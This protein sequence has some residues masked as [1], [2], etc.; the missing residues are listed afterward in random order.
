MKV[1][2]TQLFLSLDLNFLSHR[3]NLILGRL[4][5]ALAARIIFLAILDLQLIEFDTLLLKPLIELVLNL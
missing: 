1:G 5:Q 4:F 3:L 2:L